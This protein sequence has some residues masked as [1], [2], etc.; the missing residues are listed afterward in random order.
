MNLEMITG[1]QLGTF[2]G[3]VVVTTL[4]VQILKG[5]AYDLFSW[6]GKRIKLLSVIVA[7]ALALLIQLLF[8]DVGFTAQGIF[9]MVVNAL[10]ASVA[11]N[12]LYG[13]LEKEENK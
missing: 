9:L 3:M 4:L 1:G 6:E 12:G 11:S 7:F 5:A 10:L 2:A 13:W 8:Q